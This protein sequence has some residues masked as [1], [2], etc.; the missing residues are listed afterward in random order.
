M[1]DVTPPRGSTP[2][3]RKDVRARLSRAQAA[4]DADA[5]SPARARAILK[6]RAR[7]LAQ[8][9][10]E[11]A[12]GEGAMDVV[13]FR[14]GAE[15]YGIETRYVREVVP[16]LD[17]TPVP[18]APAFVAGLTSHRGQILCLID[19]GVL[20][21]APPGRSP[22]APR[23]L[24]LGEESIEFGVV[25]DDTEGVGPVAAGELRDGMLAGGAA[26]RP[27]I[28]AITRGALMILDGRLLLSDPRLCVDGPAAVTP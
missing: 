1:K 12:S 15:R 14:L 27:Y 3:A 8:R 2:R 13:A 25:A 16:F 19:L 23:I 10:S 24:V 22:G 6:E 5:V 21:Q 9:P 4:L 17:A 18:G 7:R 11:G 26:G 20:L 28:K